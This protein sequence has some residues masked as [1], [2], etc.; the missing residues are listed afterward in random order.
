MQN[1]S[2]HMIDK[3]VISFF[4][5]HKRA[6]VLAVTKWL[7]LAFGMNFKVMGLEIRRQNSLNQINWRI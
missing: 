1:F 6:Q 5:T 4:Q 7:K 2:F 3:L